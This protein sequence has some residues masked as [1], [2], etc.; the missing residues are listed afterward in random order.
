MIRMR[1]AGY[2]RSQVALGPLAGALLGYGVLYS[3]GAGAAA[4]A[5]AAS[6]LIWF[7]LAAWQAKA[8]LDAE[9]DGQRLLN[10]VAVGARR[11][12]A[13]GL[14]AA[15]VAGLAPVPL[16]IAVPVATGRATPGD[17]L[18]E[19]LVVGVW[20]HLLVLPPAVALGGWSS[21]AVT[22]QRGRGFLVLFVGVVLALVLGLKGSPVAFLAPP[23]M[24]AAR[25]SGE[26]GAGPAAL[27]LAWALAWAAAVTAAYGWVRTRLP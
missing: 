8:V 13:Y 5:F 22:R 1:L 26:F 20:A 4:Q 24:A 18:G 16:L 25:L 11:E 7:A 10:R 3:G 14:G 9:P 21:R 19:A 27:L 6:A 23:L 12:W 15:A 2:V 17:G